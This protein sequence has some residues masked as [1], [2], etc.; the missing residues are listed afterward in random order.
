MTSYEGMDKE[1]WVNSEAKFN[2]VIYTRDQTS[3]SGENLET[4]L[5]SDW[6]FMDLSIGIP[7]LFLPP[8][9]L[10]HWKN[11]FLCVELLKFLPKLHND[12]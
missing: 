10:C 1:E 2:D 12:Y 3:I 5:Y 8:Y 9:I 7:F 4:S 11:D 6:G